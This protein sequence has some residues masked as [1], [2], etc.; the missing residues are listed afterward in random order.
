L[1]VLIVRLFGQLVVLERG[2][3]AVTGE[4]CF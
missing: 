1:P 2:D 4:G 3:A